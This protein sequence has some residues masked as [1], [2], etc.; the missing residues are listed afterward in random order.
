MFYFRTV[1][2]IGVLE[3]Y[4][5]DKD[6]QEIKPNILVPKKSFTTPKQ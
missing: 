2:I 3:G 5:W 6:I 1:I 4:N